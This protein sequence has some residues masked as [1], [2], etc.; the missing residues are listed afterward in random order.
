MSKKLFA[1]LLMVLLSAV[2]AC[3]LCEEN[4][5]STD[6]L[7]LLLQDACGAEEV[8][9]VCGEPLWNELIENNFRPVYREGIKVG[10]TEAT[11]R[12]RESDRKLYISNMK[13]H[14]AGEEYIWYEFDTEAELKLALGE[15]IEQQKN[16]IILCTDEMIDSLYRHQGFNALLAPYGYEKCWLNVESRGN[17]LMVSE[18]TPFTEPWYYAANVGEIYNAINAAA[19]QGQEDF[20]L[21]LPDELYRQY[22]EDQDTFRQVLAMSSLS[23]YSYISRD[24]YFN[25]RRAAY[26]FEPRIYCATE[27]DIT[28]VI[29]NFGAQGIGQFDLVL[30][31]ELFDRLTENS[32]EQLRE[33]HTT[34]GLISSSLKYNTG[35]CTLYYDEAEI[36]SEV[37]PLSSISEAIGYLESCAKR[38]D[39]VINLFCSEELYVALMDGVSQYSVMNS[40][41]AYIY[42][43]L[44][45]AGLYDFSF[46]YNKTACIITVYVNAYYPGS[47]ILNRL[48]TNDLSGL[49]QR[50]TE[51]LDAA[52][53]WAEEI[54]GSDEFETAKNLHDRLCETVVYTDDESTDEDDTAIG[55][56]LNGQAN[57]DG[58][59]DAYYLVGSLAG[60]N[61]RCQHGDCKEKGLGGAFSHETHMWN[62]LELDGTWR[63]VDVTWD[64]SEDGIV[65]TW[66]DL[67]EDRAHLLHEWNEE[68]T[69]PLLPETDQS[70]RADWEY[71]ITDEDDIKEAIRSAISED[72]HRIEMFFADEENA[73]EL[74]DSVAAICGESGLRDCSLTKMKIMRV[75]VIAY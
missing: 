31:R 60:L 41:M 11:V 14:E 47:R 16:T 10:L 37:I 15:I 50:E 63:L 33:L 57:C 74:M 6:E 71:V 73:D 1:I 66:F 23:Q 34:S 45:Q 3:G 46:S 13:W 20:I 69:V 68:M 54:K 27:E 17:Y 48:E 32:L 56:I 26:S 39:A 21:T 72:R 38:E 44:S 51:T 52:R 62:L 5:S 43:L 9:I 18:F 53:V 58:Y 22:S 55:A 70:V 75:Y 30:E 29:R 8:E 59:S 35:S 7:R 65:Y 42:D 4:A 2:L 40:E 36:A 25:I 28:T 49:T 19:E 67:G 61:V 24:G 12:Y 64:D